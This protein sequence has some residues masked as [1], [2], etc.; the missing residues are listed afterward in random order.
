MLSSA[1]DRVES[2][3]PPEAWRTSPVVGRTQPRVVSH[4]SVE[5][6]LFGSAP[7]VAGH[8]TGRGQ[9]I[10]LHTRGQHRPDCRR[11]P[12]AVRAAGPVTPF[13]CRAGR[14]RQEEE[15]QHV[16]DALSVDSD[17][18]RLP[19]CARSGV[20]S[21]LPHRPGV[22]LLLLT[23][24]SA[25]PRSNRATIQVENPRMVARLRLP[26][27]FSDT[28]SDDAPPTI[29]IRSRRQ[30]GDRHCCRPDARTGQDAPPGA[31]RGPPWRRTLDGCPRTRPPRPGH[32]PVADARRGRVR[33]RITCDFQRCRSCSRRRRPDSPAD[34]TLRP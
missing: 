26:D 28:S 11:L 4:L 6:V 24:G 34:G 3:S 14:R 5:W 10:I 9:G 13:V 33:G 29:A 15:N 8:R 21:G 17:H 25:I 23:T 16:C 32:M 18:L 2:G 31:R 1:T 20:R 30:T 19:A 27:V 12:A 7:S 22:L